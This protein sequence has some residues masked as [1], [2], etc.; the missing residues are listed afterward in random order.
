MDRRAKIV[1]SIL[2]SIIGLCLL[3]IMA[4]ILAFL[5]SKL[6]INIFT[7]E[8]LKSNIGDVIIFFGLPISLIVMGIYRY[9]LNAYNKMIAEENLEETKDD[10][11]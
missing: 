6:D 4:Y 3:P 2:L 9:F 8:T 10:E 7:G 5:Y 1:N 11:Q